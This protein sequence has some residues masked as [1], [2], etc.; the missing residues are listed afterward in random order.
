MALNG[1]MMTKSLMTLQIFLCLSPLIT[2]LAVLPERSMKPLKTFSNGMVLMFHTG[3]QYFQLWELYGL[4]KPVNQSSGCFDLNTYTNR[5]IT[6]N[7]H[8]G[9]RVVVKPIA[10]IK[11][12][13]N[14]ISSCIETIIPKKAKS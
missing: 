7:I 5:A 4:L 8:N 13:I 2:D 11:T 10:L 14:V 9:L 1:L 12:I 3:R 6:S